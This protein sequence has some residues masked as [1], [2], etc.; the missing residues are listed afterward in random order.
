MRG[1]L[2]DVVQKQFAT[3]IGGGD[4]EGYQAE[5]DTIDQ[6]MDAITARLDELSQA[7][8]REVSHTQETT[9][10]REEIPKAERT[11]LAVPYD[12]RQEAK[13]MGARWDPFKKVWYVGPGIEPEKIAKWQVRHQEAATLDPRAEFAGGFAA[14]WG[15][16]GG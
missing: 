13:A 8:Q 16:G 14:F 10:V 3:G 6:R 2:V 4:R 5:R 1:R 15:G 12:E 7:S 9:A 11:Y